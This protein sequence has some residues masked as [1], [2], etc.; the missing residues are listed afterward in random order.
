MAT[1]MKIEKCEPSIRHEQKEM[2]MMKDYQK[3]EAK[4]NRLAAELKAHEKAPMSKAH[5]KK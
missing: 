3:E 1:N 4:I 2:T 5:P